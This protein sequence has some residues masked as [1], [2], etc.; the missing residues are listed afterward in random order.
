MGVK[1][2]KNLT[3][4]LSLIVCLSSFSFAANNAKYKKYDDLFSAI[5]KKRYGLT[6]QDIEKTA[7]PFI[8]VSRTKKTSEKDGNVTE[9]SNEPVYKLKGIMNNSANINGTWY[10]LN[11]KID[12]FKLKK[13]KN[14]SVVIGSAG[15]S[16][17]LKLY[18]GKEN[19]IIK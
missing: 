7:N 8:V 4:K 13:I 18:E 10:K 14:N 1:V 12:E 3:L 19:V 17:E 5:N 16:L 6:A 11:D 15:S 2:L 9:G